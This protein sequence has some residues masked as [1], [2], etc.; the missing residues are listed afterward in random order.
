MVRTYVCLLRPVGVKIKVGG[1][2]EGEEVKRPRPSY[3]V[4]F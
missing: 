4:F 3:T 2:G 1:G